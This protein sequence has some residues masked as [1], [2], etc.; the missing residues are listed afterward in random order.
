MSKNNT[1]KSDAKD[2]LAKYEDNA[3]NY[4]KALEELQAGLWFWDVKNNVTNIN[5]QWAHN[6]GYTKAELGETNIKTFWEFVHPD[7]IELLKSSINACVQQK[8]DSYKVTFRMRHKEGHYVYLQN[9][10]YVLE[11]D[12]EGKPSVIFAIQLNVH[13]HFE[14][15]EKQTSEIIENAPFPIIISDVETNTLTYANKR[16]QNAYSL[17]H[18]EGLGSLSINYYVHKEDRIKFLT[19]LKTNGSV[20]DFECELY[21]FE[22]NIYWALMSATFIQFNGRLSIVV[23]INDINK[24]KLTE[25][26]LEHEKKQY[27]L[28]TESISDVI[29]VFDSSKG[30]LEYISPSI[31][32]LTGFS[33]QEVMTIPNASLLRPE[34]SEEFL[35][36]IKN[37]INRYQLNRS[38]P[39]EIVHE[40]QL[41]T[42]L[43]GEIWTEHVCKILEDDEHAIRIIGVTRNIEERKKTE[44]YIEYINMHDQL[45][46]MLNKTAFRVFELEHASSIDDKGY[47]ILFVDVD[48]F[49]VVNDAVGHREGDNIIVSIA[50][51][52]KKSI[53]GKGTVYRYE[54]DEFVIF[55]PNKNELYLE[56]L[57]SDLVRYITTEAR[58]N[59]IAYILTAS[60]GIAS[61]KK[62]YTMDRVLN[63]AATALHLAKRVRNSV[64]FY[65]DDM[66]DV[67]K[68]EAILERDLPN[69]LL[70][71]QLRVYFQP[72]YDVHKGV[73]TQLEALLRWEHPELGLVSPNDFI[74]IAE[75]NNYIIPITEWVYIEVLSAIKRC[76]Q[77]EHEEITVSVNFSILAFTNRV[78]SLIN[79]IKQ[80]HK[81]IDVSPSKIYV[82]ITESMIVQNSEDLL[83]A[84][85]LLKEMGI[86]IELDDFGTGYST[87]G[88][89]KELPLNT[90]KIDQSLINN[91]DKDSKAHMIVDTMISILHSLG[92]EVIIEGVE[93][94]EQFEALVAMSP[95]FIQG[96]LFS[97]PL[98]ENYLYE[99]LNHS[100]QFDGFPVVYRFNSEGIAVHWRSEWNTGIE[101]VDNEHRELYKL[102]SY[103]DRYKDDIGHSKEFTN[104]YFKNLID[105]LKVHFKEEEEYHKQ[106]GFPLSDQHADEH[107][108]LTEKVEHLYL[109]QVEDPSKK[110]D[111]IHFITNSYIIDHILIDDSV[112]VRYLKNPKAP[113]S[114]LLTLDDFSENQDLNDA[115]HYR[116]KLRES[117]N[118]QNLLSEIS[119]I[120]MWI[121]AD[122]F[123]EKMTEV[124]KLCAN[125]VNAD[126]AYIFTY[127]FD[128]YTTS[129]SHE[130]C[131]EGVSAEIDNLQEVSLDLI[132]EWV[133]AHTT[134][135]AINI[136]DVRS[137]PKDNNVREILEPQGVWSI[138]TVPIMDNNIPFGFIGF[139]SV[140]KHHM[141]TD[142]EQAILKEITNV[143]LIAFKRLENQKELDKEKELYSTTIGS[144]TEGV[145][146]IN[147]NLKVEYCNQMA[148][149]IFGLNVD[150]LQGIDIR[151]GFKIRDYDTDKPV[152]F[153]WEKL[154]TIKQESIGQN[155]YITLPN[156]TTKAIEGNI[157]INE[158][159]NEQFGF[160]LS[161]R[162]VTGQKE[163]EK[164]TEAFFA[165][166][167]DLLVIGSLDAKF[168]RVN[169]AFVDLFGY[170]FEELKRM[171]LYDIIDPE[172]VKDAQ[173]ELSKLKN[174]AEVTNFILRGYTK[175][176]S[177]RDIEWNAK[178]GY[179]SLFYA[180]GRDVTNR[181]R[182]E[183]LKDYDTTHDV[184]TDLY[185][186]RYI[187]DVFKILSDDK[188]TLPVSILSC[189]VD[190]LKNIN[191]EFGHA[192]GDEALISISKIIVDNCRPDEIV[193]RYGGDEFMIVLKN[194]SHE[195]A[196][197]IGER[198]HEAKAH[199][200]NNKQVHVSMGCATK[201]SIDQNFDE[202]IRLADAKMYQHKR[203]KRK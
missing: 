12:E 117:I 33:A 184:L 69:A 25:L 31:I 140:Q 50:E 5:E 62:N 106:Y 130:Y 101:A 76:E 180:V 86:R 134:G 197:Q 203:S 147:P 4:I 55:V 114:T 192:I 126:R 73:I 32:N 82:E 174:K 28:L 105:R 145:V 178:I 135:K 131:Q 41:K 24:R 51:K 119:H 124:L 91:I 54:G 56:S 163:S 148:K 74:S 104:T 155:V 173:K 127:N 103:I 10:G 176:G 17:G 66:E 182:Q 45:T 1:Q 2:R 177:L 160:I 7:D 83:R 112:F 48:N 141:Y 63:N 64:R 94:R 109:E 13:E 121:S 171:S 16:A 44:S 152:V 53:K 97:R 188:S 133:K 98:P 52:I 132:P 186:R 181:L 139:D 195:D 125:N 116:R 157:S 179:G 200:L 37:A 39:I 47:S 137:M 99:Y 18:N 146:I 107:Q 194:T 165:N 169:Q 166:N 159:G 27:Q 88:K 65:K 36:Q 120:L 102:V 6:I 67:Y 8:Q 144:L 150:N 77:N 60:I 15:E 92:L 162:D 79:F 175:E 38:K 43:D 110:D 198:I 113:V 9:Y 185:N 20:Y 57:S 81:E 23:S 95:D 34:V 196:L 93:T 80:A 202:V 72:I 115:G 49:A 193:V 128:D 46:G 154:K 151:D 167:N 75:R 58:V 70:R 122:D 168:Q 108:K 26:E 61:S 111:F 201:E 35:N 100:V 3:D 40:A 90:A 158:K 118:L 14:R 149:T 96:Y 30:K 164:L 89:I 78:D 84:V 11:K 190:N 156:G 142:Y 170:S 123:D 29:W 191:D 153:N 87:F 19:E 129:N 138:L 59:E 22:K 85:Q 189:D 71:N 199:Y 161:F 187:E 183:A 68:R 21:D 42:K 143:I 136:Y 172:C